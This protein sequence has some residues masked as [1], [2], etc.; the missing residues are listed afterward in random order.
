MGQIMLATTDFDV[1]MLMMKESR[2]QC[3]TRRKRRALSTS[4]EHL[5]G[6]RYPQLPSRRCSPADTGAYFAGFLG[7][8]ARR[9][10]RD[11][12][13][14]VGSREK[15]DR[16]ARLRA[17]FDPDGGFMTRCTVLRQRPFV[18]TSYKSPMFTTKAFRRGVTAAHCPDLR[19]TWS[20]PASEGAH[21][22]VILA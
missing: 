15:G 2:R 4:A 20:P 22:I 14:V 10:A 7:G 12:G 19:S 21:V 1:F 9:Q 8:D 3:T 13:V 18:Q 5:Y 11:P 17:A 6:V 16:E